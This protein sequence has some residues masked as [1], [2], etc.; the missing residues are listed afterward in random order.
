MVELCGGTTNGEIVG[1][2]KNSDVEDWDAA[3]KRG[4]GSIVSL[5]L[6]FSFSPPYFFP[7]SPMLPNVLTHRSDTY[8]GII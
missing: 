2:T 4:A 1:K 8:S 5:S 7:Y 3:A 6:T